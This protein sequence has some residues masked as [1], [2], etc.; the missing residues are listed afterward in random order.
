MARR[1][2]LNSANPSEA[3]PRVMVIGPSNSGKSTV[4]KSL[5]NLALSGGMG[6]SVG[7]VGL[8]PANVSMH[9][10]FIGHPLF[11]CLWFSSP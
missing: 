11:S 8:D 6:W 4:V 9:D 2:H 5:L 7:V 1:S 3:G 10:G